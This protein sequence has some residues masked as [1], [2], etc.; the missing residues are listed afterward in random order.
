MAQALVRCSEIA[1]EVCAPLVG[2]KSLAKYRRSQSVSGSEA[3]HETEETEGKCVAKIFSGCCVPI[4]M[5]SVL[6]AAGA[7]AVNLTAT[8]APAVT[9]RCGVLRGVKNATCCMLHLLC[10]ARYTH[11]HKLARVCVCARGEGRQRV[12]LTCLG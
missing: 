10:I 12:T 8:Q 7:G 9:C 4:L 11:T 3:I 5:P 2:T 1:R 6:L